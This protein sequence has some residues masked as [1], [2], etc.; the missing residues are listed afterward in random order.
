MISA[1]AMA[2]A[3]TPALRLI[4]FMD[5]PLPQLLMPGARYVTDWFCVAPGERYDALVY[6]I[7]DHIEPASRVD[8]HFEQA[9]AAGRDARIVAGAIF[10]P[11]PVRDRGAPVELSDTVAFMADNLEADCQFV[12]LA[13]DV[14]GD[15]A[16]VGGAVLRFGTPQD[17]VAPRALAAIASGRASARGLS[18]ES[19]RAIIGSTSR[20]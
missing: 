16:G 4:E 14:T 18:M 12:R 3:E 2:A 1:P 7:E 19:R 10:K 11:L 6:L 20:A 17:G 15:A 13:I 8:A 9:P 5:A